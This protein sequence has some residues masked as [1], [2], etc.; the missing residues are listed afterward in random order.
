MNMGSMRTLTRLWTIRA[1]VRLAT[2]DELRTLLVNARIPTPYTLVADSW[3]GYS[4]RV[5]ATQYAQDVAGL[6]LMDVSHE[7]TW[8]A[9]QNLQQKRPRKSAKWVLQWE[10]FR[11]I[12]AFNL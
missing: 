10:Y 9:L 4:S 3:G 5:Y 11:I 8:R 1:G 12:K 2:S 6:V 7:N